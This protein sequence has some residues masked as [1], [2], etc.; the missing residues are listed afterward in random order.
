MP[1]A[2]TANRLIDGEVVY[3][4]AD[5]AW[6]ERIEGARLFDTKAEA[7]ASLEVGLQAEREQKVVHAYLFDVKQDNGSLR[8]VWL[9][10]ITS[11]AHSTTR[12]RQTGSFL[13]YRYD[14]FDQRAVDER[15]LQ[16]SG[17]VARR[18]A[19][20]MTEDEF[21]PLRLADGVYLQLHAYMLRVAI[22]YGTLFIAAAAQARPHRAE[23]RQGLW[24]FHDA[25]EPAV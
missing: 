15:V 9:L 20:E 12:P 16:F 11:W 18:L 23:V 6:V 10:I 3:L 22:P 21:K 14:E 19:G 4:A 2:L 24:P 1:Q 8:P 7:E 25:P 5:G 17:Q 13:M